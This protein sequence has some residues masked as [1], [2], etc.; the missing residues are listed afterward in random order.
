MSNAGVHMSNAG[1]HM[2]NAGVHMS[3]AGVHMSNA[4]VHMSTHAYARVA[5]QSRRDVERSTRI[6][7]RDT[8]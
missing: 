6:S 1:V 5:G 8:L 3:N 2:S 7:R 4:G